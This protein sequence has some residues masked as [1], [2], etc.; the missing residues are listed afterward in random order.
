MY[1]HYA[2][3]R[4]MIDN[5]ETNRSVGGRTMEGKTDELIQE[6]TWGVLEYTE[7]D[8]LR[9]YVTD[10]LECNADGYLRMTWVNSCVAY[11]T[12]ICFDLNIDII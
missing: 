10:N 12:T 3:R 11:M 1:E 4:L 7:I 6:I 8:N 9:N 2:S 5:L